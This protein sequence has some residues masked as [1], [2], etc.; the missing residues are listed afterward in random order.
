MEAAI[1][2]S[3]NLPISFKTP[4]EKESTAFYAEPAL[5]K[6]PSL[7]SCPPQ[8]FNTDSTGFSVNI[9]NNEEVAHG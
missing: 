5:T 6:A 3:N 2:R 1:E 9:N 8:S 4:S 7:N